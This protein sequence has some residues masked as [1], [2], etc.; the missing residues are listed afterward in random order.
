MIWVAHFVAESELSSP[1]Y[2]LVACASPPQI[3]TSVLNE[4]NQA[5]FP[6]IGVYSLVF[7]IV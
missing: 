3:A 5:R 6:S 4:G 1:F 7:I 2:L